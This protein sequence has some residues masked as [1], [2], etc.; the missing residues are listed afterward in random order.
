MFR[1]YSHFWRAC[2]FLLPSC[3]IHVQKA[4]NVSAK[5][6]RV[7][8]LAPWSSFDGVGPSNYCVLVSKRHVFY[9][10]FEALLGIREKP[11][12][13]GTF[14]ALCGMR[15]WR[16][17]ARGNG[18]RRDIDVFLEAKARQNIVS[19]TYRGPKTIVK[20]NGFPTSSRKSRIA[21]EN[22]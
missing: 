11:F 7:A 6:A 16:E 10:L 20:Y 15:K 5:I 13:Y 19:W 1:L 3:I 22:P 21:S 8:G 14:E 12:F 17:P 4:M 9:E 18:F 2:C